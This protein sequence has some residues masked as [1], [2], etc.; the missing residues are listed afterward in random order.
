MRAWVAKNPLRP[1]RI[2]PGSAGHAILSQEPS[3]EVNF[4]PHPDANPRSRSQNLVRWQVNPERNWGPK[5]RARKS[6]EGDSLEGRRLQNQGKRKRKT[7][8]LVM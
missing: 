8:S 5:P 2:E 6:Y 3:I 4:E 1:K 7:V